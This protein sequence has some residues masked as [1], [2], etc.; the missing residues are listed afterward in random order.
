MYKEVQLIY[1]DSY[2]DQ[3]ASISDL[4]LFYADQVPAAIN[5][6]FNVI[7]IN[8]ELCDS[9][10]ALY[11]DSP[12]GGQN[13]QSEPGAEVIQHRYRDV[14]GTEIDGSTSG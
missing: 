6:T 3:F 10:A 11:A 9:F 2:L 14:M 8:G 5:S 7:S 1:G 13:N 12:P 4:Q